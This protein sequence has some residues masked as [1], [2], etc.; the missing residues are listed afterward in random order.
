MFKNC[1]VG[2]RNG[3]DSSTTGKKVQSAS[4]VFP[5]T[6]VKMKKVKLACQ[7]I[8]PESKCYALV[9]ESTG[10][11][12][13][14]MALSCESGYSEMISTL[15]DL[16]LPNGESFQGQATSAHVCVPYRRVIL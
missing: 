7:H 6:K 11:G 9:R 15:I 1:W 3:I 10:G 16:F 14:E 2:K 13:R 12:H 5:A 8:N 4:E